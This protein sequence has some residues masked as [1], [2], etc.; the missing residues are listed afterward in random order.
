MIGHDWKT[1]AVRFPGSKGKPAAYGVYA[2]PPDANAVKGRTGQTL[3]VD[4][5]V[6]IGIIEGTY[7]GSAGKAKPYNVYPVKADRSGVYQ[8]PKKMVV[9]SA[10]AQSWL[11]TFVLKRRA[12]KVGLDP[13]VAVS[14]VENLHR[15]AAIRVWKAY[16]ITYADF[17]TDTRSIAEQI[18]ADSPDPMKLA[19]KIGDVLEKAG[20][21]CREKFEQHGG[22]R[23]SGGVPGVNQITRSREG[24]KFASDTW[25]CYETYDSIDAPAAI[26]LFIERLPNEDERIKDVIADEMKMERAAIKEGK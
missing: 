11:L 18:C 26:D 23:V 9:G 14:N 24:G 17:A 21:I 3:S 6:F 4:G 2:F 1:R 8:K 16:M 19:R 20:L 22:M 7:V 12:R 13:E 25:Q 15:D 10:M 5:E